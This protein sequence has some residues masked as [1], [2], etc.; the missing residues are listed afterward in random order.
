M[1]PEQSQRADE[2]WARIVGLFGGDAVKRK[3]G[4]SMPAEW[5][6]IIAKLDAVQLERGM[7]R[8]VYSGRDQVPSLPAFVKLC[9]AVG[10][11]TIDDEPQ[12]PALPNP[13][14]WQG[15]DWDNA[16]NRH[17]LAHITRKLAAN[18][19]HYGRGA[20]FKALRASEKD[21]RDLGLDRHSLD[22]T[23]RFVDNIQ[24]LVGAKNAWAADMRDLA[25]HGNA[26]VDLDVQRECWDDYI[27]GAERQIAANL[28][29]GAA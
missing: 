6:G 2:V 7:R 24:R 19:A 15:D 26:V 1:T 13:D 12:A 14:R 29:G 20:S 5:R 28:A 8:L 16:A 21:L 10:D 9:R 22:A 25:Q 4:P 3:Y 27:G 18:P 23:P 11:D 17:L